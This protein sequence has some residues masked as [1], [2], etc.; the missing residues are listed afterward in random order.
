MGQGGALPAP[1]ARA[2]THH[3]RAGGWAAEEHASGRGRG[4]GWGDRGLGPPRRGEWGGGSPPQ[5]SKLSGHLDAPRG[6]SAQSP[7]DHG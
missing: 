4:V 5:G 7:L 1:G 3:S 2:F 6:S